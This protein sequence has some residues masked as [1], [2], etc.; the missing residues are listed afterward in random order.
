MK[1]LDAKPWLLFKCA[2]CKSKLEADVSDVKC[3]AGRDISGCYGEDYY[4]KCPVCG[5]ERS[6]SYEEV[7]PIAR[8][9]H[10]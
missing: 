6:L 5:T 9:K 7:P 4:V 10:S 1:V 8:K 2:G 3:H